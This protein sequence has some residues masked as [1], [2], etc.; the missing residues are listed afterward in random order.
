MEQE[1]E[2]GRCMYGFKEIELEQELEHGRCMYGFF[3]GD[4]VG[5]GDGAR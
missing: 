5:A 4:R 1:L 3:K 2:Q